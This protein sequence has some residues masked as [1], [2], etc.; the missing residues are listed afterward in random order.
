M[1]A[2]F[3]EW[4]TA[5]SEHRGCG[6]KDL[7]DRH[8]MGRLGILPG[9]GEDQLETFTERGLPFPVPMGQGTGLS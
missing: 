2:G 5:C 8:I 1:L 4:E 3:Q 7:G 9:P 6:K